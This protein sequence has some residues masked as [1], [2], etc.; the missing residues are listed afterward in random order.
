MYC[1]KFVYVCPLSSLGGFSN[2]YQ[3]L[4][5]N[6]TVKCYWLCGQRQALVLH[7]VICWKQHVMLG[8]KY[9]LHLVIFKS[10]SLGIHSL[11]LFISTRVSNFYRNKFIIFL[12]STQ[13]GAMI[14]T[15]KYNI[16]SKQPKNTLKST[17]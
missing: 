9:A 1:Q 4:C 10:F 12:F 7:I 14:I 16:N 3:H 8:N 11:Y 17:F 15:N 6:S 2:C 5:N 13:I